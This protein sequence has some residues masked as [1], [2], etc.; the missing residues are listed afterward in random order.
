M[1]SSQDS[2]Y[3]AIQK[4]VTAFLDEQGEWVHAFDRRD[5]AQEICP[6][7]ALG[8]TER[9]F[10]AIHQWEAMVLDTDNDARWALIQGSIFAAHAAR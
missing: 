10:N 1:T 3:I 9:W 4:T 2:R 5:I 6:L 8:T 7:T